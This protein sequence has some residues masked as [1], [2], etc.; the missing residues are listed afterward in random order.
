MLEQLRLF[1]AR[2]TEEKGEIAI[3]RSPCHRGYVGIAT[4][5]LDD[6]NTLAGDLKQTIDSGRGSMAPTIPRSSPGRR[7]TAPT[8]SPSSPKFPAAWQEYFDQV[9][10]AARAG[11]ERGVAVGQTRSTSSSTSPVETMYHFRMIHYPPQH[12]LPP[13]EGQLGMRGAHRLRERHAAR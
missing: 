4:E 3:G 9:V 7:Y 8:N 13:A 1:F 6:T 12:R 10:E 5:T 2:P 11:P